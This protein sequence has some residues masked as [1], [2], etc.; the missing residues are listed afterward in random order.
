MIVV[1]PRLVATLLPDA[2]VP[3]LGERVWGDTRIVLPGPA[4]PAGYRDVLT[5]RLRARVA[6][7]G[8]RRVDAARRRR[9]SSGFPVAVLVA[10]T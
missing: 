10:S 5:G 9:R 2:D 4:A 1:V 3:P 8:D 7:D 6:A